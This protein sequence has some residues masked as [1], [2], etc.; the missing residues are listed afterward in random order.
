M[1]TEHDKTQDDRIAAN[2]EAIRAN[3][4]AIR[5]QTEYLHEIRNH[6]IPEAEEARLKRLQRVVVT[7][8]LKV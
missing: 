5:K 8:L 6:F 4:E 2:A 7:P 1:V 3:A